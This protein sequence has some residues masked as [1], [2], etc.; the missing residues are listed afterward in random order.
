MYM[1]P[2]GADEIGCGSSSL[3]C[4]L[5]LSF[6][7]NQSV[8]ADFTPLDTENTVLIEAVEQPYEC[9]SDGGQLIW[10][11]VTLASF[12]RDVAAEAAQPD[13]ASVSYAN[14][15]NTRPIAEY[16]SAF[17]S[18]ASALE[19]ENALQRPASAADVG[20]NKAALSG[21]RVVF[22]CASQSRALW[23][24][25]YTDITEQPPSVRVVNISF[26]GGNADGVG[27][28]IYQSSG[29][30][31]LDGVHMFNNGAVCHEDA[32]GAPVECFGAAAFLVTGFAA[33]TTKQSG[34][35]A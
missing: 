20:V 35:G 16:I 18:E 12:V 29:A 24:D 10:F 1:C 23:I 31:I 13:I 28:I 19:N 17:Q 7:F 14:A 22:D 4:C 8:N 15:D 32:E 9:A 27:G 3:T 30:L 5:T 2:S 25:W 11:N 26:T 21:P 33:R 6:V 34:L